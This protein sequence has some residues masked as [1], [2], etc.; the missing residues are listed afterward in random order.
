MDK[1]YGDYNVYNVYIYMHMCKYIYLFYYIYIHISVKTSFIIYIYIHES[2]WN[3]T[4]K[5]LKMATLFG[6]HGDLAVDLGARCIE[7][8]LYIYMYLLYKQMVLSQ[9]KHK[10]TIFYPEVGALTTT[11]G[12]DWQSDVT[13][14]HEK[15]QK[16]KLCGNLS[17]SI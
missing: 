9:R 3:C 6:E 12:N 5:C 4:S 11:N 14:K 10:C 7:R 16:Q 1:K 8:C 2:N 17:N 15:Q 13:Q